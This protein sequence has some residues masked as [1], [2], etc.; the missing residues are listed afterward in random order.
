MRIE[1][2]LGVELSVAYVALPGGTI[3][4]AVGG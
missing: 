3:V 4:C 1:G 2:A